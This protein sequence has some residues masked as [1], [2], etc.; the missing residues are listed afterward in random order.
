MNVF[1]VTFDQ[2]NA[3]LLNNSILFFQKNKTMLSN[4]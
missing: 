4:S 1:T 2:I 3:P